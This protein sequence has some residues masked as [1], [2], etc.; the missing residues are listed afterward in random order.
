MEE[1]N[2]LD[3]LDI[4]SYSLEYLRK[5]KYTILII[6]LVT[7]GLSVINYSISETEYESELVLITN[8][9]DY[10]LVEEIA[11]PLKLAVKYDKLELTTKF[12]DLD[13]EVAEKINEIEISEVE[14]HPA[15]RMDGCTF[16]IKIR[17]EDPSIYEDLGE[18]LSSYFNNNEFITDITAVHL[19]SLKELYE[20]TKMQIKRLDSIQKEIPEAMKSYN[21]KGMTISDL[22]LGTMYNQ[23]VD[24]KKVETE[25]MEKI[26]LIR[27]FKII[28]NF[29]LMY[30]TRGVLYFILIGI[31]AGLIING[32]I[33]IVL[34]IR[35]LLQNKKSA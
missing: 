14:P 24:L 17:T 4:I 20:E 22:N 9:V 27:E 32:A 25:T 5:K 16:S 15:E 11:A 1:R 18:P 10:T 35:H 6:F 28:N 21:S 8:T 3:L 2:E 23:M 12:L 30:V 26:R 19:E 7:I 29:S 34:T 31:A 33:F 13:M